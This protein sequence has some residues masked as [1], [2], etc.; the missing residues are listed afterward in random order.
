LYDMLHAFN[1]GEWAKHQWL[2]PLHIFKA[3]PEDERRLLVKCVFLGFISAG[4]SQIFIIKVC[5]CNLL[6]STQK[7]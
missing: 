6:E 3:T 1:S 2:L 5:A 7:S 4:S